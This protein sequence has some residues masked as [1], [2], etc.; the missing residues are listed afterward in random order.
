MPQYGSARLAVCGSGKIR[1]RKRGWPSRQGLGH[2]GSS[3][4]HRESV[5]N[6]QEQVE[7]VSRHHHEA[8]EVPQGRAPPEPETQRDSEQHEHNETQKDFVGHRHAPN[9]SGIYRLRYGAMS[10]S[11]WVRS[12]SCRAAQRITSRALASDMPRWSATY[13]QASCGEGPSGPACCVKSPISRRTRRRMSADYMGHDAPALRRDSI[14]NPTPP[15][16]ILLM[17]R[18]DK[19]RCQPIRP[20]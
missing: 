14:G 12:A 8:E 18:A 11:W 17:L 10:Q 13:R 5:F 6:E 1:V 20:G 7:Q 15:S 16:G 4:A 2:G 9:V 19:S 3:S